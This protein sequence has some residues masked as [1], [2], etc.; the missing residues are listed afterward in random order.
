MLGID[1]VSLISY[2]HMVE[3]PTDPYIVD[4]PELSS[5]GP[6]KPLTLHERIKS[7]MEQYVIGYASELHN[8]WRASRTEVT[9]ELAKDRLPKR[10]PRWKP[11]DPKN[12]DGPKVDIA[13]T[14]YEELPPAWQAEN[15]NASQAAMQ[16]ISDMISQHPDIGMVDLEELAAR[17]H[18]NWKERNREW[19][20]EEQMALYIKLP[21]VE[22]EKDRKVVEAAVDHLAKQG[23][24]IRTVNRG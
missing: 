9:G 14:P 21:P 19:A 22:K 13:N 24:E 6:E 10:E 12:P 20:P 18:V 7:G 15:R 17:T 1:M 4:K 8:E 16:A 5:K 2:H 23:M 3:I 11:V